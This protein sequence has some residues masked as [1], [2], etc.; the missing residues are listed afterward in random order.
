[1]VKDCSSF[2]LWRLNVPSANCRRG[3]L[4]AG[5]AFGL[6]HNNGGR[7]WAFA[8]WASLVGI[9][10]GATFLYTEVSRH[11]SGVSVAGTALHMCDVSYSYS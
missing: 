3:V 6:L 2:S 1:M 10:Y 8:A 4:L 11:G 5:V 9:A 7:N